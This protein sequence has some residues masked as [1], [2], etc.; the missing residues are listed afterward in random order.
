MYCDYH[1]CL[2]VC[3]LTSFNNHMPTRH[4]IFYTLAVDV[5]RCLSDDSMQFFQFFGRRHMFSHDGVTGAESKTTFCFVDFARWRHRCFS[6]F[7]R[8]SVLRM[9]HD[10]QHTHVDSNIMSAGSLLYTKSCYVQLQ[11]TSITN[12]T[13]ALHVQK[14]IATAAMFM[15]LC[16]QVTGV[17]F[18]DSRCRCE[19]N[20]ITNL[21]TRSNSD[22]TQRELLTCIASSR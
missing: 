4:D 13:Y 22:E 11:F 5:A 2:S 15:T 8:P 9:T 14:Y 19:S 10:R 7:R 21:T 17:R 1:V 6:Y 18:F 12:Q 16:H 3:P 20:A